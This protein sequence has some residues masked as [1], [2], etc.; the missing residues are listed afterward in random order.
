MRSGIL[1]LGIV[2]FISGMVLVIFLWPL[3]GFETHETFEEGDIQSNSTLKYVGEVTD[4]GESAGFYV[5]ELDFGILQAYTDS[6]DFEVDDTVVVTIEYGDNTTNWDENTYS[7]ER[8]PTTS[9]LLGALLL[10][11]GIVTIVVGAVSK[12]PKLEDLVSFSSKPPMHP[13]DIPDSQPYDAVIP[14]RQ[15]GPANALKADSVTCPKCGK[16]FGVH[17]LTPPMKIKCPQCGVE[18]MLN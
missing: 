15:T 14:Q 18:G 5:L 3:M 10:I 4:V 13:M 12:R 1:G 8:V 11:I 2:L 6:E 16:V 9:G 7:V 17:G